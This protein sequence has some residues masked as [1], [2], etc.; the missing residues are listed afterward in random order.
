[1][2]W[3]EELTDRLLKEEPQDKP[4]RQIMA[5]ALIAERSRCAGIAKTYKGD[6]RAGETDKSEYGWAKA[7]HI[8]AERIEGGE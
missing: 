5:D 4:F 2:N 1:M 3:A 7:R 8:I 6:W